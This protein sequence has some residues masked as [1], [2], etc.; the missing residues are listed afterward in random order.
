M[1]VRSLNWEKEFK[2]LFVLGCET[3][4]G[5]MALLM[6]SIFVFGAI[7][8][9][10]EADFEIESNKEFTTLMSRI[11]ANLTAEDFTLLLKYTDRDVVSGREGFTHYIPE[12]GEWIKNDVA[13]ITG[14]ASYAFDLC[15]TIGYGSFTAET[16]GGRA[17]SLVCI[18]V[19][20]PL[21]VLAYTRFAN[22]LFNIV[23]SLVIKSDNQL[24][25]VVEK[26]GK[27]GALTHVEIHEIFRILEIKITEEQIDHI[28]NKHDANGDGKLD[29]D[30]FTEFCIKHKIKVG[31]LARPYFQ[32]EFAVAVFFL[33]SI[34]YTILSFLLLDFT[35]YDSF[36]FTIVT[37]STVGLGDIVPNQTYRG[38]F[39]LFAFF[40]IGFTALLLKAVVDKMY[41]KTDFKSTHFRKRL[42]SEMRREEL[43]PAVA[44]EGEI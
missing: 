27:D 6:A 4:I 13:A 12:D 42:N 32:V 34:F 39:S 19:C 14:S 31:V 18:I 8:Q 33:F 26:Y 29:A 21:A 25:K 37:I 20:F 1:S 40:G 30:E 5:L 38:L 2:H 3:T 43:D 28:L 17:W 9:H 11:Q 16:H 41:D 44:D 7:I 23:S 24:G 15:S 10:Y 35:F 36:Y 22:L